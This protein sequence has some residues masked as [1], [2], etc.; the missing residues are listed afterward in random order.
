MKKKTYPPTQTTKQAI[1]DSLKQLM[2]KKDLNRITISEIMEHCG[3]A[4]QQF[5]YHFE[6]IY[7]LVRWMFQEEALSLLRQQEGILLWQDGFLQFLRYLQ[8]NRTICLCALR[9]MGREHLKRFFQAEIYALIHHTIETLFEEI[10]SSEEKMDVDLLTH[11]YVISFAGLAESWLQGEIN[12]T[13]EELVE[14]TDLFLQ[15]QIRGVIARLNK[16]AR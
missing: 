7:D 5:Y 4:R 15:D 13:P 1:C 9:S 16:D 6:D 2:Q 10:G 11:F 12:K 8:E 14:F 3:M